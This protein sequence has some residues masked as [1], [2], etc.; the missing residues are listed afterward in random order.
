[1]VANVAQKPGV[2]TFSSCLKPHNRSKPIDAR[3]EELLRPV[4]RKYSQT[5]P[6]TG[7]YA[8]NFCKKYEI[9]TVSEVFAG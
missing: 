1:M 6:K 4:F 8:D 2:V 5:E 3:I 7:F 9:N